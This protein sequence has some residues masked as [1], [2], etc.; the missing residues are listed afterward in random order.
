MNTPTIH[1]GT[2]KAVIFDVDGTLY[3]QKKLRILILKKLISYYLIRPHRLSDLKIIHHFRSE[4]ENNHSKQVKN[5]AE[6]QYS[7][8]AE[9]A[10]VPVSKVKEVIDQWIFK[11]PLQ[12]LPDCI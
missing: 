12:I 1:S 11:K 8:A 6:E 5:L 2:T 10:G 4:R 7:W 9:S 3:N